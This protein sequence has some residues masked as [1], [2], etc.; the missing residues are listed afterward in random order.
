MVSV[1]IFTHAGWFGPQQRAGPRVR[2]KVART[3]GGPRVG[4]LSGAE[5]LSAPNL[6]GYVKGS[7]SDVRSSGLV[8]AARPVE[9][10]TCQ[11]SVFKRGLKLSKGTTL[12]ELE[13]S[14]SDSDTGSEK[15]S[16]SSEHIEQETD[17]E[18]SEDELDN[19]PSVGKKDK[20]KRVPENEKR[21]EE[22]ENDDDEKSQVEEDSDDEGAEEKDADPSNIKYPVTCAL[23]NRILF[24]LDAVNKHVAS[25]AHLKKEAELAKKEKS[26][27]SDEKIQKLKARNERK[28]QRRLEKKRAERAAQGHV[29]GAHTK[30]EK[31]AVSA[32]NVAQK[33]ARSASGHAATSVTTNK[34]RK[35]AD[36]RPTLQLAKV[37][38]KDAGRRASEGA[39]GARGKLGGREAADDTRPGK[40]RKSAGVCID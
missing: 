27:L 15:Q 24:N 11:M 37:T 19:R 8:L 16:E 30:P 25:K 33:A 21:K 2:V 4:R 10:C 13:L 7:G 6:I 38:A 5:P 20:R 29:W 35:A 40:R 31:Q 9:F 17:E 32:V 26:S 22:S 34:L 36:Q 14:D 1:T 3:P 39:P 23:C 18:S 28:R 12:D